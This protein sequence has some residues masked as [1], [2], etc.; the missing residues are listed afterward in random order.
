MMVLMTSVIAGTTPTDLR[1]PSAPQQHRQTQTQPLLGNTSTGNSA[2]A[3]RPAAITT[4]VKESSPPP[5][6]AP[7]VAHNKRTEGTLLPAKEPGELHMAGPQPKAGTMTEERSAWLNLHSKQNSE[8]QSAGNNRS[9]MPVAATNI[10]QEHV[11]DPLPL[12]TEPQATA[13]EGAIAT[14]YPHHPITTVVTCKYRLR[15]PRTIAITIHDSDGRRLCELV[16]PAHHDA[17]HYDLRA[18]LAGMAK[19]MYIVAIRTDQGEQVVQQI[20]VQ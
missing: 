17:G 1:L 9:H 10:P 18:D 8:A 15:D 12:A 6:A 14:D 7:T 5:A 13:L 19:G 11:L 4:A 16:E 20:F 2:D 3:A